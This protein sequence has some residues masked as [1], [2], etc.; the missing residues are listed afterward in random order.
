MSRS[1]QHLVDVVS[2]AHVRVWYRLGE[3]YGD[4]EP[5]PCAHET[6]GTAPDWM[7]SDYTELFLE[8]CGDDY[9][10]RQ[11]IDDL[12]VSYHWLQ[13]G[14]ENAMAPGQP[15]CVQ[16]PLEQC[17]PCHDEDEI[18]LEFS[19]VERRRWP[20]TRVRQAWDH[21]LR[22]R[23]AWIATC[24]RNSEVAHALSKRL[25]HRMR[26]QV[27]TTRTDIWGK[28]QTS[29]TLQI[30]SPPGMHDWV[31]RHPLAVACAEGNGLADALEKLIPLACAKLHYL[32]PE[33]IRELGVYHV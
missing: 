17:E 29:V 7:D 31:G 9:T 25:T 19:I 13:W 6:V 14:L 24:N 3:S 12:T 26:I 23:S 8:H 33:L 10:R 30:G 28:G 1:H 15:F 27:H 5:V 4:L 21:F 18:H 2:S 22:K 20:A 11:R 16:A 32:S